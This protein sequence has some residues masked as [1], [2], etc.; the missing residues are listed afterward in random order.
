[1]IF[2][3]IDIG[4]RAAKGIILSDGTI[5]S[6]VIRDT[7][8]ESVKTSYAVREDLLKGTELSPDDTLCQ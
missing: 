8:P 2:A 3:G 6:S 4:S 5:L 1:M 7:G